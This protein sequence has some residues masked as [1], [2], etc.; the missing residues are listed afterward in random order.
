MDNTFLLNKIEMLP[1]NMKSELNDFI[2]FLLTKTEKNKTPKKK[3]KFGSAKGM[4][5]MKKG[6]DEPL[7]DFKNYTV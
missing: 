4:L 5:K 2:D 3:A 1:E 7:E 6:F